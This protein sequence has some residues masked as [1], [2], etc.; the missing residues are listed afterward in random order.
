MQQNYD[1]QTAR[2]QEGKRIADEIRPRKTA[3]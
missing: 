1:L 3:A 2:Q